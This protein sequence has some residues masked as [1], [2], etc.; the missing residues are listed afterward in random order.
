MKVLI[1]DN[2]TRMREFIKYIVCEQGH[3]AVEASNG[4]MAVDNFLFHNPD[5]VLMDIKMKVM[6]GI[7]AAS[8]IRKMSSEVKIVMVTDFDEAILKKNALAAGADGYILKENLL[9][10]KYKLNEINTILEIN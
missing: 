10:L 7:E 4:L 9:M 5:L 2:N 6:D 1:A 8:L 3:T